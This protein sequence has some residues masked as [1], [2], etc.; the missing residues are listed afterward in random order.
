MHSFI[1][2]DLGFLGNIL[3]TPINNPQ[4]QRQS[5][6]EFSYNQQGINLFKYNFAPW[7]RQIIDALRAN[8]SIYVVA[9][10]GAGKTAPILY[11]WAQN[12]LKVNPSML[13]QHGQNQN[14]V[15]LIKNIINILTMPEK[16]SKILYT[17]PTR[18]LCDQVYEEVSQLLFE[19]L[20]TSI[21]LVQSDPNS[22]NYNLLRYIQHGLKINLQNEVS[23]RQNLMNQYNQLQNEFNQTHNINIEKNISLIMQHI[24]NIDSDIHEKI[25]NAIKKYVQ[26]KLVQRAT[27]IYTPDTSSALFIISIHQSAYKKAFLPVKKQIKTIIIDEAHTVQAMPD[28][29]DENVIQSAKTLYK[30]LSEISLH[31]NVILLSGTINPTSA[32]NLITYLNKCFNLKIKQINSTSGNASKISI[33]P[34]N[35]INNYNTLIKLLIDPPDTG[36]LIIIFSKKTIISLI[37]QAL[38]QSNI[39]YTPDKINSGV[40]TPSTFS[41]LPSAKYQRSEINKPSRNIQFDNKKLMKL[42][43]KMPGAEEIQNPLLRTAVLHGFG[44]IFRP[45]AEDMSPSQLKQAMKDQQI[46][47]KLFSS[48]KIKTLLASDAVGIGLNIKVKNL[49]IPSITKFSDGEFQKLKVSNASQLYNRLGRRAFE[50]STIYTPSENVD[51][52]LNAISLRNAGFEKREVI[53]VSKLKCSYSH[54]IK[55][56]MPA[57]RKIK[58]KIISKIRNW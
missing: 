49:Y 1:T 20:S 24:N 22:N 50:V 42:A 40:F 34:N 18:T 19:I 30:I 11:S 41:P 8:D 53:D 55:L 14:F 36:N 32:H 43:T 44:Y 38:K 28:E 6:S 27:K 4:Q 16:F 39:Q 33:I 12:I 48:G 9:S 13:N 37:Q 5:T 35:S 29:N 15:E 17:V 54:F 52:I 45:D 26:N 46:V 7:Q 31:T 10:P 21:T 47:I 25:A 58:S 3:N 57:F 2:E 56:Y 51:D 23:Q